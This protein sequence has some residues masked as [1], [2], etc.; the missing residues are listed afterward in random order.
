MEAGKEKMGPDWDLW[1][2][3]ENRLKGARVDVGR[4]GGGSVVLKYCTAPHPGV[5]QRTGGR[6]PRTIISD[7][8]IFWASLQARAF[9]QNWRTP[10]DIV[11]QPP[12]FIGTQKGSFSLPVNV[13]LLA[14]SHIITTCSKNGA[15]HFA[16][17]ISLNPHENPLQ[18]APVTSW[19]CRHR[20]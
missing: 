19:L 16:S 13:F 11:F 1:T 2:T 17:I 20:N 14:N 4:Q 3:C 8:S 7:P 15:M 6:S 5:G 12:T 9:V 10:S 18:Q